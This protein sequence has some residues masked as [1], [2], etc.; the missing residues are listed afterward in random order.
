MIWKVTKFYPDLISSEGSVSSRSPRGI[1]SRH[2]SPPL[3]WS[4]FPLLYSTSALTL[5]S[6][7]SDHGFCYPKGCN[8]N[9]RGIPCGA[10]GIGHLF[11]SSRIPPSASTI[12]RIAN[13]SVLYP[14]LEA[15][16]N[17][18]ALGI[19]NAVTGIRC[20]TPPP[21]LGGNIA[22]IITIVTSAVA[23][24][25]GSFPHNSMQQ[26]REHL[27][28]CVAILSEGP[29][30]P[31]PDDVR[32]RCVFGGYGD[33]SRDVYGLSDFCCQNHDFTVRT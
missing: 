7:Q 23:V 5:V 26:S 32:F 10:L 4:P 29:E 14:Y 9:L 2:S 18:I 6:T 17:A 25:K 28:S 1:P 33:H 20:P 8:K 13:S 11:V 19:Q 30:S 24:C 31:P 21:T 15:R 16:S 27:Q 22:Q 12:S 3:S